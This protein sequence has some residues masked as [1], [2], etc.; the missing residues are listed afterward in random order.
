MGMKNCLLMSLF[1]FSFSNSAFANK[2]AI[3]VSVLNSEDILWKKIGSSFLIVSQPHM[4]QSNVYLK[5]KGT[6][7]ALNP[8]PTMS[9]VYNLALN[10]SQKMMVVSSAGEGHPMLDVFNTEDVLK[11]KKTADGSE[12]L[13]KAYRNLNPYP[14]VVTFKKW[15]GEDKILLSSDVLL[16][17]R[18]PNPK[19]HESRLKSLDKAQDFIWDLTTDTLKK[20]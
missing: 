1:L 8:F 19:D 6:L 14:G 18:D 9:Y 15:L 20:K 16:S 11:N 2:V 3:P 5:E 17:E 12:I 4:E 13:L 7:Y 10:K